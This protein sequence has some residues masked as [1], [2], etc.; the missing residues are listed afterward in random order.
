MLLLI[1]AGLVAADSMPSEPTGQPRFVLAWG[2]KGDKPGEFYSPIG[3]AIN[4]KD[5]VYVTDLNNARVQKDSADGKYLIGFDLPRDIPER[6]SAQ[7]GG[8]LIGPDGLIYLSFMQQHRIGVYDDE[9]KL[10]RE[11][12]KKGDGEGE[13]NQPGG[14]V[15]SPEG[16]LYVAD[17]CNHRVQK[18]SREGK[19]LGQWGK[20]GTAPGEFGGMEPKGS[21]FAGPHFISMDSKKRLYTSEAVQGRIQQ[22]TTDGMPLMAWGSKGDEP[23]GFGAYRF[24]NLKNTFGPIGVFVDRRDRVW[25]SSL[26]DRVQAFTSDGKYL[27]AIAVSG[28]EPGQLSRPHGMAM[29]SMGF[30]YVADASNQR[31]QKFAVP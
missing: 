17:Q 12:G 28:K 4:A 30:L 10:V 29:D 11:W 24:G 21:R 13:F 2:Q 8:I 5:E 16:V 1:L 6:K 25:V 3:I 22:L 19:F 18:F 14:M 31:I 15:L 26:N 23:G 7:A 20:H 27:H 9:G